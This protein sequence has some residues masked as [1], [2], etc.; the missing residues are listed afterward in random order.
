[1]GTVLW[2]VGKGIEMAGVILGLGL[3]LAI[4]FKGPRYVKKTVRAALGW[5]E[6]KITEEKE[7][8]EPEKEEEVCTIHLTKKQVEA[9]EK[10]MNSRDFRL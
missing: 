4:A 9:F 10:V 1:M 7:E 2:F 8:P 6:E 3:F 5:L